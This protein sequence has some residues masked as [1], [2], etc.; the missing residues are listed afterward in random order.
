MFT[1]L[2][3]AYLARGSL[4]NVPNIKKTKKYIKKAF[5][6][7]MAGE[8]FSYVEIL[9][10]CPTNWNIS[11]QSSIKRIQDVVETVY[12]LGEFIE[13]GSK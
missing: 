13:R 8:G 11:P 1:G 6:K 10:P 7:Q 2:D 9:S 3:I 4:D 5:E 12:P